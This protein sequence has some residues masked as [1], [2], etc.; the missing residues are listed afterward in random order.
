MKYLLILIS[1]SLFGQQYPTEIS[2]NDFE[3]GGTFTPP[4]FTPSV[5][6]T[7][8]DDIGGI[9]ELTLLCPED[10]DRMNMRYSKHPSW[11]ADS[12][13][14][15]AFSNEGMQFF[16]AE[17]LEREQRD[18]GFTPYYSTTDADVLYGYT[19]SSTSF[20]KHT[21]STN[22]TEAL[23]DFGDTYSRI[24]LGMNEGIID[25]NDRFVALNCTRSGG[26]DIVVFDI[27]NQEIWS[28]IELVGNADWVSISQSGDYLI[29][30]YFDNGSTFGQ[31]GSW[32]YDNTQ[33]EPTNLRL[34]FNQTEH[35]APATDV[36]GEDVLVAFK[37]GSQMGND[38]GTYMY[39][40]RLRDSFIKYK[41]VDVGGVGRGIYGGHISAQNTSDS[42][43]AFVTETCCAVGSEGRPAND[44]FSIK[45]DYTDESI[46]RYYFRAY[47]ERI[48]TEYSAYGTPNRD[49]TKV[50]F[51]SWWYS[52]ELKN[53]H[54]HAPL[55]LAEYPQE[56]LTVDEVE[57]NEIPLEVEYF[58]MLGQ[59]L[60]KKKP[61]Q[62]GIYIKKSVYKERI[63][64]KLIPIK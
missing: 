60:G 17:T 39:M 1:F 16:N 64:T 12:T 9:T 40:A 53:R 44:V 30:Q 41:F 32:V 4:T 13:M 33:N 59:K 62:K 37:I 51:Q 15:M 61:K 38:G 31:S 50:L 21:W 23:Y 18:V 11:N 56:T 26:T 36:N 52:D 14:F 5:G 58:N 29:V 6:E 25:N 47:S 42:G 48:G 63:L 49:G 24:E 20:F 10:I 7:I 8:I 3:W 34:L 45:L 57:E 27:L 2:T 55:W 35:A 54:T 28:V 19:N 43:W 22:T 46:M